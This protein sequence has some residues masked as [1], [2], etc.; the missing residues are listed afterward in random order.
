MKGATPKRC[1]L[2]E[3]QQHYRYFVDC[4]LRFGGLSAAAAKQKEEEE[5]AEEEEAAA[6][7]SEQSRATHWA[8]RAKMDETEP[9]ISGFSG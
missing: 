6:A 9:I 3:L 7:L 8:N 4:R 5:E 1:K 2:C